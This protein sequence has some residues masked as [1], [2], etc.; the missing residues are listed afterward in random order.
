MRLYSPCKLK[1]LRP[2]SASSLKLLLFNIEGGREAMFS[3]L[4]CGLPIIAKSAISVLFSREGQ[5]DIFK[6]VEKRYYVK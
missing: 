4:C 6:N 5:P 2:V 1:V 3:A